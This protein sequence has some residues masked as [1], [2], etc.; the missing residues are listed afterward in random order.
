MTSQLGIVAVQPNK[1]SDAFP[2]VSCLMVAELA[3]RPG[4]YPNCIISPLLP[5]TVVILMVGI[6]LCANPFN[7]RSVGIAL[8]H[9]CHRTARHYGRHVSK[10][11]ARMGINHSYGSW[12]AKTTCVAAIVSPLSFALL[13][14]QFHSDRVRD[15]FRVLPDDT[16]GFDHW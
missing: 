6:A 3:R 15:S 14:P 12:M 1:V 10:T 5:E 4:M 7:E 9:A 2:A 16:R 8:R 13:R 11:I